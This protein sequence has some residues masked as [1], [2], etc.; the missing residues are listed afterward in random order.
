MIG[1]AGC[2]EQ[3]HRTRPCRRGAPLQRVRAVPGE[4]QSMRISASFGTSLPAKSRIGRALSV[5]ERLRGAEG[6]NVHCQ[7]SAAS[8]EQVASPFVVEP[9]SFTASTLI[10]TSSVLEPTLMVA[11]STLLLT[12]SRLLES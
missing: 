5:A 1:L 8:S 6:V 2:H 9:I 7:V 10:D 11:L 4:S 12:D 3:T